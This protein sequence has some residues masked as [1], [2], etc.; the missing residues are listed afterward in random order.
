MSKT[1]ALWLNEGYLIFALEGPKGVKIERLAK[2]LQRN[3]SAFYYFFSTAEIFTDMLLDHHLANASAMAEK[4]KEATTLETLTDILI[5]HK[6]DLLFNKQLRV[7]RET[8]AFEACFNKTNE[9][10]GDAFT[11]IW[12]T[13]I[14]LEEDSDLA[15]LVLKLS[16]ENFF[17]KITPETFY[18]DWLKGYFN[19]FKFLI[20]NIKKSP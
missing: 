9:S 7:N 1:E 17:L 5:A 20:K 4:M 2:R 6:T 3:K 13:I 19:D 8:P 12:S 11:P 15:R 10:V 14:G 18:P 16:V